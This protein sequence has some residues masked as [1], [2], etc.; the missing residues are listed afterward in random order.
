MLPYAKN[1]SECSVQDGVIFRQTKIVPPKNLRRSVLHMLYDG[2]P[3]IIRMIRIA[4]PCLWWPNIAHNINSFVQASLRARSY[5]MYHNTAPKQL[6]I[7]SH[8]LR[9]SYS[10]LTVG[11]LNLVLLCY[12][13]FPIVLIIA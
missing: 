8:L 4:R 7:A 10:V 1:R 12:D 2:H 13:L 9:S 6:P 11:K 3:G 5:C